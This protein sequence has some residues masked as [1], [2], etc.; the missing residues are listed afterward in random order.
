[1]SRDRMMDNQGV[2]SQAWEWLKT[3]RYSSGATKP[4]G[5]TAPSV[6]IF[7]SEI[8][9]IPLRYPARQLVRDMD[10]VMEFGLRG[11]G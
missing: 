4:L 2:C 5:A 1:M 6:Y 9:Q 7:D 3:C 10:S 11:H 8:G